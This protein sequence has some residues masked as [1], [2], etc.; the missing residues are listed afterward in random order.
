MQFAKIQKLIETNQTD[1][2]LALL[3]AQPE[4]LDP[5]IAI[6]YAK[7][8]SRAERPEEA[9]EKLKANCI[10]FPDHAPSFLE[11]AI[12]LYDFA[13]WNDAVENFRAVLKLQPKNITA[14]NYLGLIYLR[15]DDQEQ[16]KAYLNPKDITDNLGFRVRLVEYMENE[17]LLSRRF[18][19]AKNLFD[20]QANTPLEKKNPKKALKYFYSR[21]FELMSEQ[22]PLPPVDNEVVAFLGAISC[23]MQNR[24]EDAL[25]YLKNFNPSAD[26][27]PDLIKAAYGRNLIRCGSFHEGTALLN[28]VHITGPEDYAINY[29]RGIIY[30]AWKNNAEARKHFSIALTTYMVDTLDFQWVQIEAALKAELASYP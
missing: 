30:L 3:E 28:Q 19:S 9:I 7:A 17:W 26:T 18:F 13:L 11:L 25:E 16:S 20:S 1:S 8:L 10:V 12:L 29:Y 27:A 24:H 2:A 6:T 21:K 15:L 14:Q 22:L 4:E 23:E 5:R